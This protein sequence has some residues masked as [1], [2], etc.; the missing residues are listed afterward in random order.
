METIF[1]KIEAGLAETDA[2]EGDSRRLFHGRGKT[3]PGFE[4]LTIDWFDRILLVTFFDEPDLDWEREFLGRFR[5]KQTNE[6]VSCVLLQRRYLKGTPVETVCGEAP[7]QAFALR[8]GL[9]FGLNLKTGQNTG[10]FLDME[11]GRVWLEERCKGK[12][13]LNLFAYTCAFSVVAIAGRAEYVVNVDMSSSAL[14]RGRENHRQNELPARM[15]SY[16]ACN[17]LKSWG[18]IKRQG[19]YDLIV[20]DPPSFQ[21]G[22]FEAKRDYAKV[23]KRLPELLVSRGEVLACLNAPELRT[24]FLTEVFARGAPDLRFVERLEPSSDFPD[25][26]SERQLKLMVFRKRL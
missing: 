16:I 21:R 3:F 1:K 12:R 17:V 26:D 13:V 20:M 8:K 4:F 5:S 2:G 6:S 19:P 15:I 14:N 25:I 11:P 18:R 24:D 9:R 7:D 10:F 23:A 22:S